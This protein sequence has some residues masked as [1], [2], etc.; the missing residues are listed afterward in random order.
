MR[1]SNLNKCYEIPVHKYMTV[2]KR[3]TL[4]KYG[5]VLINVE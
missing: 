1:K 2:S 3:E 5:N 4:P